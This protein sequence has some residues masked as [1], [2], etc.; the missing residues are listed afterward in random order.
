MYLRLLLEQDGPQD[1]KRG[2]DGK[3]FRMSERQRV[4]GTA[5]DSSFCEA[6]G[7]LVSNTVMPP[8]IQKLL[9]LKSPFAYFVYF[10]V[11]YPYP[12]QSSFPSLSKLINSAIE[13]KQASSGNRKRPALIY[14]AMIEAALRHSD[15]HDV[16]AYLRRWF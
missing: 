10:A 1:A 12:R 7:N 6:R 2:G 9:G 16:P 11:R 5:V 15:G 14:G 4:R 13:K 3:Q 8:F